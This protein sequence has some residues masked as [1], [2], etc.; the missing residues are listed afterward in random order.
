MKITTLNC[1]NLFLSPVDLPTIGTHNYIKSEEKTSKL[2]KAILDIDADIFSLQEASGERSLEIFCTT[3][4][5]GKYEYAL[6]KGN[7]KRNIHV[8]YLI[9]KSLK[10]NY[11]LA[12][13]KD[14]L[15]DFAYH[16]NLPYELLSR[17]ISELH[18]LKDKS[19]ILILL[20]IHLKSQLDS[21][22]IDPGGINRRA[23]EM[24]LLAK[25]SASHKKSFPN[26]PQVILGDFNNIYSEDL[27]EFRHF[28]KLCPDFTDILEIIQ[29]CPKLRGTH[30]HFD[31][32]GR[33]FVQQLDYIL[34][35]S[36]LRQKVNSGSG[37]IYRYKDENGEAYPLPDNTLKKSMMPSDHFPVILDF[38]F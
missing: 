31:A 4:L 19:P 25:V 37:G 1:E 9:K 6:I 33:S 12:S 24:K 10:L 36:L 21:K 28:K 32:Y 5:E 17:D 8:A 35:D 30:M 23:A 15:L 3:Y 26:C 27:E 22:G 16:E 11:S 7:S 13:N 38:T 2:A 29:I 18:L 34:I 14:Q 20:G